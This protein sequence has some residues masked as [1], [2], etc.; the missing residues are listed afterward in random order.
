MKKKIIFSPIW[1][2]TD[3]KSD[4]PAF[5]MIHFKNGFAYATNAKIAIRQSLNLWSFLT[6]NCRENLQGKSITG[7][8]LKELSKH[9]F[10]TFDPD[11]IKLQ[12]GTKLTYDDPEANLDNIISLID[13]TFKIE[14]NE[15]QALQVF[16][17]DPELLIRLSKAMQP[18]GFLT[19]FARHKTKAFICIDATL[20]DVSENAGLF[21]PGVFPDHY[22]D[23]KNWGVLANKEPE[24]EPELE[25]DL[26]PEERGTEL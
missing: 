7:S 11:F 10:F 23:P 8:K 20:Q 6:E 1:E 18:T 12:D 3:N 15:L 21:M 13:L 5:Q 14:D 16:S 19:F 9:Q 17:L 2:A 25:P 4:R 24:P 22:D 26:E